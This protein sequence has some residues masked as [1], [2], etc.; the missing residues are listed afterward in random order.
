[1][2]LAPSGVSLNWSVL[3]FRRRHNSRDDKHNDVPLKK[4]HTFGIF[5][6]CLFL[7][8]PQH[9]GQVGDFCPPSPT[10]FGPKEARRK[11]EE[12]RLREQARPQTR[13]SVTSRPPI[14]GVISKECGLTEKRK[15][16]EKHVIGSLGKLDIG[17]TDLLPPCHHT[18]SQV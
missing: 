16:N 15:H 5:W 6:Q 9:L 3:L 2:L 10:D 14:R 1:M 18:S 7:S 17:G 13:A 12:Q 8:M 4:S 11:A